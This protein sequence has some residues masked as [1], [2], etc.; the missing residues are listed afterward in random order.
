MRIMELL[1]ARFSL[2]WWPDTLA[3]LADMCILLLA[4]LFNVN[5]AGLH[6]LGESILLLSVM[7]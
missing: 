5:V 2:I 1:T 3:L 6:G 4:S 7:R